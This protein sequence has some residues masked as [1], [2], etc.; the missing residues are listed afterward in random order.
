MIPL[1]EPAIRAQLQQS[2]WDKSIAFHLFSTIDSTNQ[3]L[4]TVC[5]EQDYLVCCAETQTAGRGRFGRQWAS[6]FGENIYFSC[7]MRLHKPFAELSGLSLVMGLA[8]LK[9]LKTGGIRDKLTL[10]WPN[11]LMWEDKKLGGILIEL[12]DT[13][14][15]GTDLIIGI[16][17]NVN[18]ENTTHLSTKPSTSLFAITGRT[19]DRNGLIAELLIAMDSY[20]LRFLE[21]GFAGFYAEWN[22]NDYLTGKDIVIFNAQTVIN[23]VA[24]GVNALGQLGLIDET[25][26]HRYF[27]SG[28]ASLSEVRGG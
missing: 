5:S 8:L 3:F 4:K 21:Q 25:G 27:A 24:C 22:A 2:T 9:S 16:G 19:W 10:K 18:T 6:P 28:E 13:N 17:I 26:G 7:K 11:D 15:N 1:S 23:G 20:L 12:A 14:S